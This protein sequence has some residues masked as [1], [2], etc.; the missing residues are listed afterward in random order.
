MKRLLIA[1]L[2][3]FISCAAVAAGR[4]ELGLRD[5]RFIYATWNI[6]HHFNI[7]LE[8]S[9]YSEKFKLQHIRIAA[10]Y[11]TSIKDFSIECKPYFG[12]VYNGDY[13]DLG[14]QITAG[15]RIAG[16]LTL[17]ATVNPHYDSGYEYKTCWRAGAT[18][19]IWRELSAVAQYSTV[20]EYRQ[21]EKRVRV[22]LR[23]DTE[24][25]WIMPLLSISVASG[26]S[27]SPRVAVS[28][29]WRI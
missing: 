7:G 13:Y 18:C 5:T 21:S 23:F 28:M 8:H 4:V 29:G 3:A 10:A 14:A 24:R 6:N 16:R 1:V 26:Q 22:G 25:L 19:R 15:Y 11:R 20:P 12:T 17:E 2:T 9:V 27:K